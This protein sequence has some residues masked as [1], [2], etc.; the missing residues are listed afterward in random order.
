MPWYF[1]M[2]GGGDHKE[3]RLQS[4]RR[5]HQIGVILGRELRK[6]TRENN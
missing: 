6:Y 1:S 5:C 3:R 2:D 4:R